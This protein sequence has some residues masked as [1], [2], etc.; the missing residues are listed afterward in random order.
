MLATASTLPEPE[1][2]PARLAGSSRRLH[3][4]LQDCRIDDPDNFQ[5][6][7]VSEGPSGVVVGMFLR[8]AGSPE[9]AIEQGIGDAGIRLIHA[10][11][12]AAG[13]EGLLLRLVSALLGRN[14]GSDGFG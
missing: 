9:L 12:D 11:H 13:G 14:G 3:L 1:T 7:E 6:E 4:G 10:D 5:V 2:L 8:I